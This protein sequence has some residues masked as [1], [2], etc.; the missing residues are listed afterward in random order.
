ME[1][2][3]EEK[4]RRG[5][6][7][8]AGLP[9]GLFI[10]F[11]GLDGSGKTT[12]VEMLAS[13]LKKKR[14]KIEVVVTHEPGGTRI[15]ELIR[16]ILLNPGLKEMAHMT[17]ALLYAADRAQHV[18]EL[19][20]PA[21]NEGKVVICD[22]FI[23]SSLAYQ[24]V[25]RGL[26]LEGIRNLNEWAVGD[27]YPDLTF[28]LQVSYDT[29]RTRLAQEKADR[30]EVETEIFHSKV[31]EAYLTLAKFFSQRIVVIDGNDTPGNVHKEIVREVDR[32]I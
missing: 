10:T 28:L 27:L 15:G 9:R 6:R 21:L 31:Q 20:R 30:L 22:R 1:K 2:K 3:G 26:G 13:Y 16:D 17:E 23:D 18:E 11:E 4:T 14:K 5:K 32:H 19:I 7:L 24:G 25:A 8:A 29:C 12:Q